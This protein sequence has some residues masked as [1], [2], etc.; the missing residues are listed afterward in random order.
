MDLKISMLGSHNSLTYLEP[1]T[2]VGKLLKP[3]VCCQN[4][5]LTEQY[6]K[7]VRYFDIRV[8]FEKSNKILI[9]HNNIT[10]KGN[11]YEELLKLDMHITE[12]VYLRVVLDVRK[13]PSNC[14]YLINRFNKF[15]SRIEHNNV[16]LATTIIYWT[17]C[18][19]DYA[20]YDKQVVENHASVKAK[21]YEFILGLKHYANKVK[22]FY[23]DYTICNNI[24]LVDYV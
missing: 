24:Y 11:L 1:A 15:V 4:K 17:W 20:L 21:W 23:C 16:K 2:L 22:K 3:W 19:K 5:T 10:F 7:G 6:D 18:C 12:P 13:K 8:R 14:E 9:V